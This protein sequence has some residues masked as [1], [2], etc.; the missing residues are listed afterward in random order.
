MNGML[1]GPPAPGTS[2]CTFP[3]RLERETRVE[4]NLAP[5]AYGGEYSADVLGEITCRILENGVSVPSQGE[6]T[7]RVARHRKIRMV[8]QVVSFR[9]DCELRAFRQSEG[10]LQRQV[11]LCERGATQDVT[12]GIAKLARGR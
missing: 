1:V 10:L 2:D 5:S 11:K 8:E 7:L 4:L 12:P 6:R 3:R 9:S